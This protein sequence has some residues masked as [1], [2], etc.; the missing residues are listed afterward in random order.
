MSGVLVTL[1]ACLD[2]LF[3]RTAAGAGAV[4]T[5]GFLALR[6]AGVLVALLAGLDVQFMAAA[7][8][9]YFSISF[10]LIGNGHL[11]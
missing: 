2:M 6:R 10:L 1:L 7:L 11:F 9:C 8:I 5:L 4:G 3:M